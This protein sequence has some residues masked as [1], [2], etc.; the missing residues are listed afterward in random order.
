MKR[1]QAYKH[2][3]QNH[4]G[5]PDLQQ[6]VDAFHGLFAGQHTGQRVVKELVRLLVLDGAHGRVVNGWPSAAHCVPAV[7]G[8]SWDKNG[9]LQ[10]SAR[11][12]VTSN[13]TS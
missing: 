11:Q 6:P 4:Q 13:T 8:M 9:C 5:T 1:S 2:G 7:I 10:A 12:L 3:V